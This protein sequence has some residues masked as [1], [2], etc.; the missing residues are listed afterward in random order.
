MMIELRNVQK[1]F[2]LRVAVTPGEIYGLIGHNGA[3]Q[4]WPT[5]TSALHW[6]RN[7]PV[8]GH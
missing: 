7:L 2:G 3:G 4:V 8:A 6:F 1:K 5:A